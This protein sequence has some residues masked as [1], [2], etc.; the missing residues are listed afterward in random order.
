MEPQILFEDNDILVINKPSGMTVN[1]ADTN[2]EEMTV[3]KWVEERFKIQDSRFKNE[4]DVIVERSK[5]TPES[6]QTSEKDSGPS[7]LVGKQTGMTGKKNEGYDI[8]QEFH[9]RGGIV[10]RLDKGTSGV[11]VIAKNAASFGKLKEQFMTRTT[12]KVYLALAHGKIVPSEGEIN[13]PVGRLPFNRMHF[14]VIAGGREAVTRYKV[15]QNYELRMKN[16]AEILSLVQLFPKT[17]RTHQ[18]R[19]HLKYINHPIVADPL[20]AGRKVGREDRK[21]LSRL[22]LHASQLTFNHPT[23]GE[24]MSVEAPLPGELEKF[25]TNIAL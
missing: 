11:L 12:E 3:Q 4:S 24:R 14:G 1:N 19:V 15:I 7:S 25:I 18:I 22:F 8:V 9:L 21:M 10:H 17:G 20:Y 16:H 6:I 2:R 13:A 5:T 23:T